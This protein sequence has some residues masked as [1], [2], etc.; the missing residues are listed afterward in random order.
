MAAGVAAVAAVQA[1]AVVAGT[2]ER[3]EQAA[4]EF[5]AWL[6]QYGGG[7]TLSDC[8]PDQVLVYL[9]QHWTS[10]HRG[11]GGGEPSASAV[12]GQL[13]FLST[14]FCLIG[15]GDS[16]DE[17]RQTGNPCASA[18][19]ELYWRGY[20]RAAGDRGQLEVSAVP[21]TPAKYVALVA[22][23]WRMATGAVGLDRAVLLRDLLCWQFM[24][25]TAT[26]GRDCGKL[27]VDDFREP[28][29]TS[30]AYRGFGA[31]S[32]PTLLV[33]SQFGTKT[34]PGRRAPVR[35]IGRTESEPLCFIRT[36]WAYL[37]ALAQLPPAAGGSPVPRSH[38]IHRPSLAM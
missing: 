2:R 1:Q 10:V 7:R 18:D 4:R 34:Y 16:Y 21:L 30:E 13:S 24:W 3:Q 25:Q 35:E 26:R 19:V 9:Q 37:A 31:S 33:L 23:L 36:L 29:R 5:G 15:R 8:T 17:S 20:T 28:G 14:V 27:R 12:L 22:H 38:A 32:A 11:R 6:G